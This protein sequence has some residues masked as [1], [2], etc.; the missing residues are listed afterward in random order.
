[1]Q[2]DPSKPIS[3]VEGPARQTAAKVAPRPADSASF[4][5]SEKL[6]EAYDKVPD[7]RAE[8]I[9]RG[10]E[11]MNDKTYPPPEALMRLSRLLAI[12]FA[13]PPSK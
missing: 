10:K 8:K 6:Q 4:A 11:I 3:A 7:V 1:M 5:R 2:I 13:P 12:E 9:A